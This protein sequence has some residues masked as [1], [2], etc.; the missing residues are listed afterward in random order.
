M[1]ESNLDSL[2]T[3]VIGKPWVMPLLCTGQLNGEVFEVKSWTLDFNLTRP[4][5]FST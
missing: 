2:Y 1:Y 4:V 3:V 5:P